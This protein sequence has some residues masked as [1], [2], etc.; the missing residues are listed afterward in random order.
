MSR[1]NA[2]NEQGE[3]FVYGF[4]RP[5]SEYFI[6]KRCGDELIDLVGYPVNRGTKNAFILCIEKHGIILPDH[7]EQ[8]VCMDLPFTDSVEQTAS[9]IFA[10]GE[11]S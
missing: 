10:E 5:L 11:Q 7:H 4:D 8:A 2:R 6:Q 1:Y 9:M 3:S